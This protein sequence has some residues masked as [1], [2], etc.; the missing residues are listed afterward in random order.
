MTWDAVVENLLVQNLR[1]PVSVESSVLMKRFC[2]SVVKERSF[3]I[4]VS[5]LV[6]DMLV[7]FGKCDHVDCVHQMVQ[8][9]GS[10][11]N[12]NSPSIRETMPFDT[13]VRTIQCYGCREDPQ[14][15]RMRLYQVFT[16]CREKHIMQAEEEW[17][18]NGGV[19]LC[20]DCELQERKMR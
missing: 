2:T 18:R 17:I 4:V 9:Q 14:P 5:A 20:A 7:P 15:K 19:P 10:L 6:Y 8:G 16:S 3:I 11:L 1:R 13:A 12:S